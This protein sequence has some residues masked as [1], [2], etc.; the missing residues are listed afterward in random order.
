MLI[1]SSGCI[2][3]IALCDALTQGGVTVWITCVAEKVPP[4]IR[5]TKVSNQVLWIF[6]EI[7]IRG[8][9]LYQRNGGIA[10][11]WRRSIV[12]AVDLQSSLTLDFWALP[13]ED[14]G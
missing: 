2:S 5:Y 13:R 1:Q 11:T 14:A 10:D 6:A 9:A 7:Q 4:C 3:E 12:S 8:R